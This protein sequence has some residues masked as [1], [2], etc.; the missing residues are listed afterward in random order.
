MNTNTNRMRAA[1]TA[2]PTCANADLCVPIKH[3]TT[4]HCLLP[5]QHHFFAAN[6]SA[7]CA[8]ASRDCHGLPPW[9]SPA[10]RTP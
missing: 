4:R 2:A 8:L 5:R 3:G 7:T 9:R 10:A 1:D 6:S